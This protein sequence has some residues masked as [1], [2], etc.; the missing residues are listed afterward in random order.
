MTDRDKLLRK[1]SQLNDRD[2][3]PIPVTGPFLTADPRGATGR[4]KASDQLDLARRISGNLDQLENYAKAN[5]A[6]GSQRPISLLRY[7]AELRGELHRTM[8]R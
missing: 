8:N 1:H 7:V 2:G 4:V 6:Q 3:N 5:P